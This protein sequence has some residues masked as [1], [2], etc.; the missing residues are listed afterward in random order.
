MAANTVPSQQIRTYGNWRKPASSGLFGLGAVG[1]GI[2]FVGS[3][4]VILIMQSVGFFEASLT[5]LG[6]GVI[7]LLL[8]LKDQHGRNALSRISSRGG[9]WF[10]RATGSN[11]YRSGP[12]SHNPWGTNQLP[13]IAAP[14]RLSE[15]QDSYNRDFAMIYTPNSALYTVVIATEPDGAA[16]VDQEQVDVWVSDYGFMLANLADEPGL[17]AASVTIETAPDSGARL[18]REVDNN[19]DPDAPQFARDMMRSVVENYPS[20]SSTVKAYVA[21]T[22]SALTR[23]GGKRRKPDEM[24]RDL[25]SRL[26]GLTQMLEATGAGAAHPLTAQYLCEYLRVAY[27]PKAASLIDSAHA[28][29]EVPEMD[30]LDVGPSAAEAQWGTYRHDSGLSVTW[31]MTGAPRGNVQS[32]VLAKLLAPHHNIARKRVTLLYRPV[33]AARAAGMVES[34]LT[35][36]EFRMTASRKPKARDSLAV[37]AAAATAQEEASGAGLVNFGMLVTATVTDGEMLP[38]AAAAVDGLGA[39][40][41]LRLRPVYGSQDSA[42]AAALPLGLV[43]SK[44]IKLPAEFRNNL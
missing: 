26:P 23:K 13:G 22:F 16:L 39:G 32:G 8:L 4:V 1:T 43:M 3:I 18:R 11:V 19:L 29:G 6:I 25:A 40:A 9:H 31:S 42:F 7:L 2:L 30:W 5:A 20:G 41:R 14:L 37:R 33:P 34:D 28:A 35:S 12:V 38:D 21:F 36:A 27:D 15:H 17:E 24:A 10:A 44:H